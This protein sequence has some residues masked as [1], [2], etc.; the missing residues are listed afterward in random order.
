M[1]IKKTQS[2]VASKPYDTAVTSGNVTSFIGDI[3][4]EFKKISWTSP[5]ELKAYTKIVVLATFFLGMGLYAIDLFIQS[6][7]HGLNVLVHWIS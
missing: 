6:F 1:E 5:E 7:I 2:I 3:K 4:T